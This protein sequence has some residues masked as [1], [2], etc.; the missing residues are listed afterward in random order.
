MVAPAMGA[1]VD[2][3][4]AVGS[5]IEPQANIL[6]GLELLEQS[7]LPVAASSTFYCTQPIDRPEQPHYRN[8]VWRVRSDL[9]V[10]RLQRGVLRRIEAAVGRVRS[11]DAYAARQL[12]LD[13][14]IYGETVL[15][16]ADFRVPD[17]DIYTRPFLARAL[18]EV[19]P[20]LRLSDTGRRIDELEIL[21]QARGL[22]PD[23]ALTR[24]INDR[25]SG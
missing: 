15:Y 1:P 13:V 14:I 19:A 22:E 21:A 23:E 17:P 11:D 12:D 9:P 6:K 8:G 7:G 18:Q 2:V 5:N 25:I 24:A 16:E 4:I 20:G 3:Y 10:R